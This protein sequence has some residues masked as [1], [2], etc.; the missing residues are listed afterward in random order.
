MS[1]LSISAGQRP[2][3]SFTRLWLFFCETAPKRRY[4]FT[5]T[6]PKVA[7]NWELYIELAQQSMHI[8]STI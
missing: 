7:D 8:A 4:V 2:I 5:M 3:Y 1:L 6:P